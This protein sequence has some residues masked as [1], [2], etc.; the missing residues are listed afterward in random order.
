M[1]L[2]GIFSVMFSLVE[3]VFSFFPDISWDVNSGAVSYFLD[4]LRVVFYFFPMR[5]VAR[6]IGLTLSLFAIRIAISLIQSIWRLL[7]FA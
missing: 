3:H 7:P 2:E 1:L 5:D 4:T 6:I